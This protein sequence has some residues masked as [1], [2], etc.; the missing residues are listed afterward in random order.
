MTFAMHFLGPADEATT[1][2]RRRIMGAALAYHD[3]A[4]WSD[5]DMAYLEPSMERA[6][7][8]LPG[9]GF[10]EDEMKIIL[11]IIFWHHKVRRAVMKVTGMRQRCGRVEASAVA[12]WLGT[13]AIS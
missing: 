13:V 12:L 2:Q 11:D 1:A 3:I 9:L 6:K 7:A 4:L 5:N 8:D 10:T